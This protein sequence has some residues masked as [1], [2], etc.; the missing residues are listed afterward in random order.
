MFP[1]LVPLTALFAA[2]AFTV[3]AA[4]AGF[5]PTHPELWGGLVPLVVLG[6]ITPV[7]YAVNVRIIPVFSRRTWQQPE[8][9]AG[10]I[11]FAIAGAWLA[12]LAR[13][14]QV[15]WLEQVAMTVAL[16]GGLL[17][18]VS[19][20][21]LFHSPVVS[22]VT[23]PVPFPEQALIDRIG[24]RFTR[25]AGMYLL[26]GLGVGVMLTFW[27]PDRGRWDLVWAHALLLG[28]FLNMASGVSYHVLSRWT[29]RQW[30]S[31]RMITLHL[32]VTQIALPVMIAALAINHRD[33]FALGGVLQAAMLLLW[34][35]NI[36]PMLQGMP[37]IPRI[38]MSL[39][40]LALT[41][42][43]LLG[44]SFA[45]D[46]TLGY[47]LRTAHAEINLLG[48]SGLLVAGV[49]YYLFPRFAGK[50]LRWPR[51]AAVQL[52]LQASG[53]AT[54]ALGWWW[55]QRGGSHGDTFILYGGFITSGSLLLF[56]T[57]LA[58]TFTHKRARGT[59]S[60]VRLKPVGR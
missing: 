19:I 9:M 10:A 4:S 58:A 36:V 41:V 6:A 54:L 39:A 35:I 26:V 49:G 42:G 5:V 17:F 31:T 3:A 33:L 50:A 44:A 56:A 21:R 24:I 34:V 14:Q 37:M 51:L 59:V 55:Y 27:T 38:G 25:M 7:I 28:W 48:F 2:L 16:L 29:G 8:L 60:S 12:F 43:V 47:R 52:A 18:V 15:R 23:L 32:R 20:I 11:G 22:N 30:H 1:R 13:V 57:I 53:V 46:P 40:A 45:L